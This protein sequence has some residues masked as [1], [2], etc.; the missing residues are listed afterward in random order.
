M[1]QIKLM[2]SVGAC[3]FLLFVL[4]NIPARIVGSLA[5]EA[6]VSISGASGTI[7]NGSAQ[8]IQVE[9]IQLREASWT[10]QALPLLIGR[11]SMD[12]DAKW[13]N[14]FVRG[15]L[16]AG[17]GGSIS[18]R[19][20][21]A[22]GS[23]TPILQRMNLP[24]TSGELTVNLVA[25]EI[26]DL[27]PTQLVGSL[28]VGRV[29]LN[30]IGVSGGITGNYALDFDV[31]EV[32]DDGIIPGVL[33]D[34]GGPLEI[35]GELRLSPPANYSIEARIKARADAPAQLAQGL[36]LAGPRLPDGSHE[37]QMTGSL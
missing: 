34:G 31:E 1:N 3:S 10:L 36:M 28:R 4:I 25:A 6:L 16:S 30:M 5:P 14:G 32:G 29:P 2:V 26:D 7:W 33:S 20:I 19:E 13:S 12:F 37:F 21:E 23:L 17:L 8:L 22:A 9:G 24:A 27:W 15:G 35:L 11:A 18:L